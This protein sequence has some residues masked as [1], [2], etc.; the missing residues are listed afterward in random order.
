MRLALTDQVSKPRLNSRVIQYM[1]YLQLYKTY[2][3]YIIGDIR[4]IIFLQFI[5]MVSLY[6][7]LSYIQ[8]R[9]RFCNIVLDLCPS[10]GQGPPECGQ[11]VYHYSRYHKTMYNRYTIS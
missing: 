4:C 7:M 8:T 5:P 11:N 6:Y 3:T 2:K 1:V 10:R 9:K